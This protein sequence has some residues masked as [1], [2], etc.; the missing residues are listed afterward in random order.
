MDEDTSD[1]EEKLL[2]RHEDMIK[3]GLLADSDVSESSSDSDDLADFLKTSDEEDVDI[4]PKL[5]PV[6]NTPSDD[7]PVEQAKPTS[8]EKTTDEPESVIRRTS[9]I[10][11]SKDSDSSDNEQNGR[12][13]K[14]K[15][16][17]TSAEKEI[18]DKNLLKSPG[19]STKSNQL[20]RSIS[21]SSK[22]STKTDLKSP[23][24]S[25]D[26]IPEVGV[27]VSMFNSVKNR[28]TSLDFSAER[29]KKNDDV[30]PAR[31][32]TVSELSKMLIDDE[33]IS[34]SSETDSEISVPIGEEQ[35]KKKFP[36]RK[37]ILSE[38]E[39]QEETKKARKTEKE[40]LE[41]LKRKNENL[42]Q[43]SQSMM[44]Q[45]L[46]QN[47]VEPLILDIDKD[48]NTIRV[49]DALV[50]EMKPH[51]KDGVKFM[52]DS[53]YGSLKDDVKTESGCI[54]AHSMGLGK[55]LQVVSLVHVLITHEQLKTKKILIVCPK[56]TIINWKEEFELWLKNLQSKGLR[57]AYNADEKS[58][59]E[60]VE[61]VERWYNSDRPGVF[62]INY[63]AF[64]NLVH[65]NGRR[66]AA[67]LAPERVTA[68]QEK[69]KRC[70]L[71]PGPDLVVCDEGHMIKNEKSSTNRAITQIR[72]MHRIILTGTPV[73]NNLTEYYTMVNFAKPG[74]L[75]TLKEF[76]NVFNNPIKDGQH[77]DSTPGMI[78]RMKQ[79]S[80]VLNKNL[81]AFVQRKESSELAQYLPD[82][83]EYV[84]FVPLTKKQEDLYKY[85]LSAIEKERPKILND[86]TALRKIWTHPRVL[87]NA[88]LRALNGEVLAI[89]QKKQDR[90]EESDDVLDRF[91]GDVGV[92][93]NWFEKFVNG[94]DLD[95][96]LSSN[97]MILL[98]KILE[99]AEERG[100]KVLIFSN[101][102]AVL[103]VVEELMQ[104]IHAYNQNPSQEGDKFGY[105]GFKS[106]WVK[107]RD[108][109][110][111]DGSTKREER[112]RMIKAFNDESNK[113]LRCFLI[114]A[115]AGGQ[116]INL[117][118]A[119]RCIILD[120][121]W[122]P[123]SDQQNI[124]R[125]Y[126]LGQTKPCYAYR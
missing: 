3:A 7:P 125:I 101:F 103:N 74:I 76:N 32:S 54:L 11:A 4:P 37:K 45:R 99:L 58:V 15:V 52:Y 68:L 43:L 25:T 14:K 84:L 61:D 111:L 97:K 95:S 28:T 66:G 102:V 18:F 104:L 82:K 9:S 34:L 117:T 20:A 2:K 70:L 1:E 59:T 93:S 122:N 50:S 109:I 30:K 112:Q 23:S 21:T 57:I 8:H 6:D 22:D 51:Q 29:V 63:E 107:Y 49:H 33:C 91:E 100:E 106:S 46:S 55:T 5:E 110:R 98:F 42:T 83:H 38:A 89:D 62:L 13:P 87:K 31:S 119:N 126:R 114:S 35:A 53:C 16:R 36:R 75:G 94:E 88:H 27:D 118:G 90:Q 123:S 86:Y 81:S 47:E 12:V 44:S 72:T 80:L 64:R 96:I 65:F 121:S 113:R 19:T 48:G 78:K 67:P 24:K 115:K 108:Y 92:K 120:T 60:R 79:R 69:I 85:F 77:I 10:R 105:K 124:F 17:R 73:Q 116:G 56:V 39:L 41:R 26:V 71:D 40:R